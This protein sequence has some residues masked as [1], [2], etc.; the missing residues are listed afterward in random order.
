VSKL[1]ST[2]KLLLASLITGAVLGCQP[3][4]HGSN[5][6]PAPKGQSQSPQPTRSQTPPTTPQAT[7]TPGPT[8]APQPTPVSEPQPSS[9]TAP[10]DVKCS[11]LSDVGYNLFGHKMVGGTVDL[12]FAFANSSFKPFA[13]PDE[14]FKKWRDARTDATHAEGCISTSSVQVVL[15]RL[16]TG[17]MVSSSPSDEERAEI[18]AG[19]LKGNAQLGWRDYVSWTA[20]EKLTATYQYCE[21]NQYAYGSDVKTG[22]ATMTIEL[23]GSGPARLISLYVFG[24]PDETKSDKTF[25]LDIIDSKSGAFYDYSDPVTIGRNLKSGCVVTGK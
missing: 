23:R 20:Q 22:T 7:P 6:G 19:L 21:F 11:P 14:N 4:T 1:Q 17:A 12:T 15:K 16:E 8:P 24:Y 25:K 3:T 18:N 10:I 5:P 13:I 2:T 9:M